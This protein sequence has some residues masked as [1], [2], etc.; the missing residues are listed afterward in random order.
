M[1]APEGLTPHQ[2]RLWEARPE[3][4]ERLAKHARPG[5]VFVR[6]VP[7]RSRPRYDLCPHRGKV[8]DRTACGCVV[9][10]CKLHGTCSTSRRAGVKLCQECLDFPNS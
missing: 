4:R 3:L 10:A 1:P 2:A 5:A 8:L 6:T 7:A 9:H